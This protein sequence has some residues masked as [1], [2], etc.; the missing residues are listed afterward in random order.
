[1]AA[2][3]TA[4]AAVKGERQLADG[5]RADPRIMKMAACLPI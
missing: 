2:M 5:C 1:M 3:V 4:A